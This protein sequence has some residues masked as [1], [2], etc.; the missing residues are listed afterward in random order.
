MSHT[1][2]ITD[3]PLKEEALVRAAVAQMVKEGKKIEVLKDAVPRM[4]YPDQF[5]A[6]RRRNGEREVADLVL[7]LPNRRYDVGLVKNK[8]GT[9]DV[10]C[11]TYAGEVAAELG[12]KTTAKGAWGI[13]PSEYAKH[14]IGGFLLE[15]SVQAAMAAAKKKGQQCQRV[16]NPK[17]GLPQLRIP[18]YA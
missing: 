2:K 7:R 11:D 18:I 6:D 5:V 10:I 3:V 13:P 15:Y 17:T 16:V 14:S 12:T 4:Y 8:A 9:F 1:T